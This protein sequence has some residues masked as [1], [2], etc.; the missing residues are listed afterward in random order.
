M[1]SLLVMKDLVLIGQHTSPKRA[2]KEM[3]E[4]YIVF[5]EINRKWRTEVFYFEN[6]TSTWYL[7]VCPHAWSWTATC[8]K[9]SIGPECDDLGRPERRLQLRHH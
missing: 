3:D 2:M 8:V 6:P 7:S 1:F 9:L 4:L 5:T